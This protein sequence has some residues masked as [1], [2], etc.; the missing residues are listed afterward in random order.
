M[1]LQQSGRRR[2]QYSA[3]KIF[4]S[5]KFRLIGLGVTLVIFGVIIRL[6]FAL[7]FAQKLLGDLIETQQISIATYVARDID[8][9]IVARRALISELGATLR[10]ALL[11]QPEN[12]ARWVRER[13]RINTLFNRL[14]ILRPDG[15]G[16][17]ARYP[18]IE[19]PPSVDYSKSDW[20]QT[21]LQ[22]NTDTPVMSK[23]HRGIVDGQPLLIMAVPVR[24]S[25][26][27]V[28]AILAG[29]VTL[30]T[31]GFLD[32]LQDMH[33][34]ATGGFLLISPADKLFVGSSDPSMILTRTP[35]TGV[36]L[37]HDR[38]M[39]G[40][41]GSGITINAFGIEELST[42][43]SVPS[44][45]WFVV[46]RMPTAEA[47]HPIAATRSYVVI[48]TVVFMAGL[49]A[50]LL[51]LLPRILGPLTDMAQSMR[52]MADGKRQLAPLPIVRHDEVGDL[53]MGF[54]YLL[55]RLQEKENALKESEARL[56][57]MAHHDPLTGLYNRSMLEEHIEQAVAHSERNGSHFALLFC[58]LDG[59]KS[60]NDQ[61]GHKAGD[62]VLCE[63]ATRLLDGRRRTDTVAR[64]GGDEFIILLA[65]LTDAR[66]TTL[67]IAQQLLNAVAKPFHIDG[68]T[69]SIGTSIG[70]SLSSDAGTSPSQL[71]SRADIAMYRAKR[72]GKNGVCI[73]DECR[74][75]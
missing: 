68:Q 66:I 8:N 37:L 1:R 13:Q 31:T 12:L 74:E 26:R 19:Q 75:S 22:A 2:T 46:A 9:S 10:P 51:T 63:V 23:P 14:V 25:D 53:V 47:F 16:V 32:L 11:Q 21:I 18:E 40:Y 27:H 56:T 5:I 41:R 24:D 72:E 65:D 33:L 59:F 15:K 58:D 28:I 45:G 44:T 62:A 34:G 55:V 60:I 64:F 70:I 73:F 42:M 4:H 67:S 7:P 48:S 71:I 36:N 6:C 61:Y 54:N 52:E 29:I 17:F 50:V 30:N 38:A 3:M 20:F 35:P 49:I 43:V 69:F 39:A 57:F